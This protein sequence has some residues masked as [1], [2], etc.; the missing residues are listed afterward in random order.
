M[1]L[2]ITDNLWVDSTIPLITL[3]KG[4]IEWK[5][6]EHALLNMCGILDYDVMYKPESFYDSQIKIWMQKGQD[7]QMLFCGYIVRMEE[8][9]IAGLTE[10][11][12]KAKSNSCKLDQKIRKKSFQE[13]DKTY[14][15]VIRE[16]I[17]E[18]SGDVICTVG[19]NC[20]IGGTLLQ[21]RE[22][23]WE[24]CKRLA[25]HLGSCVIAN[26]ETEIPQIWFGMRTGIDILFFPE[27]E[28]NIKITKCSQ[29]NKREYSYEV[30]S[31]D[32]YKLGDKISFLGKQLIIC[33]VSIFF[34]DGELVFRYLLKEKEIYE[35]VYQEQFKGL[36]LTGT[37]MEVKQE[38]IKVALDIDGGNLTGNNFYDWCSEIGNAFYMTPEIGA[39]VLLHFIGKDER[40]AYV[41]HCFFDN[42][43]DRS[44]HIKRSLNVSDGNA[45]HLSSDS[46]GLSKSGQHSLLLCDGYIFIGSTN[47]LS[48]VAKDHV[49]IDANRIILST[50]D[51]FNIC[52]G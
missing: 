10:V 1:K 24:F 40:E 38:Q 45:V 21:Y 8:K 49:Q 36:G 41:L 5:P 48:I 43:I 20:H 12:L 30:Q 33:K 25:S 29:D 9:V 32:F 51:E 35:M 47:N 18:E 39:K 26:I 50:L 44:Y 23:T 11:Y 28:Y 22:T 3:K 17:N 4:F 27:N 46:T 16:T 15:K 34:K 2:K 37:V 19:T 42:V 13:K 52:Q 31:R 14:A 6:N 7:I